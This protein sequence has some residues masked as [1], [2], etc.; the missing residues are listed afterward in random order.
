MAGWCSGNI[1]V[2]FS[3]ASGSSPDPASKKKKQACWEQA[4]FCEVDGLLIRQFVDDG[5]KNSQ[6][7]EYGDERLCH[8][9]PKR[10]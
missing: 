2:S 9:I 8:Q 5:F 1:P 6:N 4:C 3:G 10:A 7:D